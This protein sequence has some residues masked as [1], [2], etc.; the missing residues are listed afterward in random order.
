MPG[1]IGAIF[2]VITDTAEKHTSINKNDITEM[3]IKT[4]YGTGKLLL[5]KEMTFDDLINRVATKGGITEEGT[6]VIE[7]KLPQI[8]NE[9]FKKTLEKRKMT[10]EKTQ[11]EFI[12][13]TGKEY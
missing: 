13:K 1:F 7:E 6:R 3:V 5:E 4:M 9:M 2:K 10:K 12:I 8:I 11:N